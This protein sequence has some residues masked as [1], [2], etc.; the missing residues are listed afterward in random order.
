MMLT[1]LLKNIATKQP[2]SINITLQNP[3]KRIFGSLVLLPV[4][5][6]I[7]GVIWFIEN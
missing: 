6:A 4:A 1:T 3:Q 5:L 2:T 7:F